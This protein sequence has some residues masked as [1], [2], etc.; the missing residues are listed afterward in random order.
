MDGAVGQADRVD[1][2]PGPLLSRRD[3]RREA[4][5]QIK[6]PAVP[7]ASQ[8]GSGQPA[9]LEPLA[10]VRTA[11]RKGV[12][13]IAQAKHGHGTAMD[14]EAAW[15]T[16]TE[17]SNRAHLV[18]LLEVHSAARSVSGMG[19]GSRTGGTLFWTTLCVP[20]TPSFSKKKSKRSSRSSDRL[21]RVPQSIP[22][23]ASLKGP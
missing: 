23:M 3:I 16:G 1:A 4:G 19:E 17:T 12:P 22:Q 10:I 13:R 6:A 21:F 15:T 20:S 11:I 2:H 18:P 5:G 7:A 8:D 14:H 9:V